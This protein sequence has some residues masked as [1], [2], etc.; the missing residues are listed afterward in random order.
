MINQYFNRKEFA[1]SCGCGFDAVDKVLL[2]VLTTVREHFNTPVTI[3][4]GCRCESHNKKIGG[5][6]KSY[7]VRGK[8]ADIKVRGF[9]AEE[10]YNFI[11]QQCPSH[12]GV[13]LYPSWVHIDV[14]DMKYRGESI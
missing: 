8:A 10:V 2:D 3:T 6:K 4:S 5:A 14:R 12:F 7:H 13:I 1:C 9:H 11:S